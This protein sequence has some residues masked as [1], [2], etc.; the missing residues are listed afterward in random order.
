M[1]QYFISISIS[2]FKLV[3]KYFVISLKIQMYALRLTT[4]AEADGFSIQENQCGSSKDG[5]TIA[6]LFS[7]RDGSTLTNDFE[8]YFH[9]LGIYLIK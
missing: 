3:Y 2:V 5:S 8:S 6:V 7:E 4:F 9:Y 1:Y